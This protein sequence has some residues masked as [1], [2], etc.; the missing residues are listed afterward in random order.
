[1]REVVSLAWLEHSIKVAAAAGG[2]GSSAGSPAG[3]RASAAATG[4]ARIRNS[5]GGD[6][7]SSDSSGLHNLRRDSTDASDSEANGPLPAVDFAV[8]D[9]AKEAQWGFS[10]QSVLAMRRGPRW[11]DA[12]GGFGVLRRCSVCILPGICGVSA[13]PEDEF[14]LVVSS[15]GG[16]WIDFN[17]LPTAAKMTPAWFQKQAEYA[18]LTKSVQKIIVASS[19]RV[20]GSS[21]FKSADASNIDPFSLQ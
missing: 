7:A 9:A 10:L 16:H 18:E 5:P 3:A 12:D 14:R 11:R 6:T 19:K 21:L 15:A 20:S 17:S 4:R 2:G 8:C 13:P 1:M